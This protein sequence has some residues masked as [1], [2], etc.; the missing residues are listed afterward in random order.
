[1]DRE[2]KIFLKKLL[3]INPLHLIDAVY[4]SNAVHCCLEFVHRVDGE[5]DGADSDI[6]GSLG[7]E[8]DHRQM[9]LLRNALNKIAE[10]MISIYGSDTYAHWIE[11]G[12]ILVE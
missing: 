7:T 10:K 12:R 2:V 8:A 9:E 3:Y 4:G 11:A 1:M 6:V 5:V